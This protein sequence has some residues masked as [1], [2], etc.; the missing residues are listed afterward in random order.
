MK[1]YGMTS[2]SNEVNQLERFECMVRL[3]TP[4][5]KQA[6]AF[7][8]IELLVVIA[9]I[10][11]L[12]GLL[13]PVLSKAKSKAHLIACIN[14]QRQIGIT[15]VMY[16]DD[17]R[18]FYPGYEDWAAFG[19]TVGTNSGAS[20]EVPGNSMHG[21]NVPEAK[22]P[23]N[24]YTKNVQVYR[25]PADKGDP[26]PQQWSVSP[27]PCW[28]GWGN[29]YLMAW[30]VDVYGIEHVGG[31]ELNVVASVLPIKSSRVAQRPTSKLILGDWNWYGSRP[32]TDPRTVWHR[33]QG[34]RL[35]PLL[36][37]DNHV[38]NYPFAPSYES[39]PMGAP[40]DIDAAMW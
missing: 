3:T 35:F 27:K 6:R 29:S 31:N 39:T 25:C 33:A 34:K 1:H 10:A 16:A 2:R 37:G 23:L 40:V 11:I 26:R 12:A 32:L 9:I 19:G 18:D 30:K 21:G 4:V 15:C 14:N 5:P 8:L 7:T 36:F 13:L 38:Q 24:A 17:N 28:E 22:R 20:S